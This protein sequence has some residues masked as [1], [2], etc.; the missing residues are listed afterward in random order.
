MQSPPRSCGRNVTD[1]VI[2][3][4]SA[5]ISAWISASVLS[6]S[7]ADGAVAAEFSCWLLVVEE[8]LEEEDL[9]DLEDLEGRLRIWTCLFSREV[10]FV[11]HL[12]PFVL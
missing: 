12:L 3:R 6:L 10:R 7:S 8:V 5:A 9:V 1:A 4:K 11:S 2:C